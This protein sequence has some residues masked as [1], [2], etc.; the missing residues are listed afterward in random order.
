MVV[1]VVHSVGVP[2]CVVQ[3]G[4]IK[5]QEHHA[6]QLSYFIEHMNIKPNYINLSLWLLKSSWCSPSCYGDI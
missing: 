2:H 5:V 1:M 4:T 6:P 3:Q